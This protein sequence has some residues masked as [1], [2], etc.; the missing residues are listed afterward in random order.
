MG[1]PLERVPG[2]GIFS[3]IGQ[4]LPADVRYRPA[5][6]VPIHVPDLLFFIVLHGAYQLVVAR[7]HWVCARR[8]VS[9][10]SD[11]RMAGLGKRRAL[12]DHKV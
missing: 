10:L 6:R 11:R 7:Y 12:E 8:G 3:Q 9:F 5:P 2:A 4:D 1:N